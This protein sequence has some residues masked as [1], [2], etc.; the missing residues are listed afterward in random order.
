M[1][2]KNNDPTHTPPRFPKVFCATANTVTTE[3]IC[4][5][6]FV[7]SMSSFVLSIESTRANAPINKNNQHPTNATVDGK[8][9]A[10][11]VARGRAKNPPPIVVPAINAAELTMVLFDESSFGDNDSE[12]AVLMIVVDLRWNNTRLAF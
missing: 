5:S 8:A 7:I 2:K 12:R 6:S 10:G 1:S 4:P 3:G 9:P 11:A